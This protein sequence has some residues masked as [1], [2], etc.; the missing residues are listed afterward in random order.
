MKTKNTLSTLLLVLV[1][2]MA[3]AGGKL[4]VKGNL[5]D[6]LHDYEAVTLEV[7]V[8]GSEVHQVPFSRKGEF[9]IRIYDNEHYVLNFKR[10]GYITKSIVIDTHVPDLH[11][12]VGSI[13]FNVLMERVG[14]KKPAELICAVYNWSD[15]QDTLVYTE[16]DDEKQYLAF[17]K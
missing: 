8:N 16:P 10:K 6:P 11:G 7:I 15:A 1:A 9:Q 2:T 14:R 12:L 17:N 13:E 5:L 3:I 4:Q